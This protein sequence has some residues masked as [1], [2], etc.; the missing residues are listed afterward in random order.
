MRIKYFSLAMLATVIA[1][2]CSNEEVVET[3]ADP[4]GEAIDFLPS[5]GTTRATTTTITNLGAFNVYAKGIHVASGSLFSPFLVGD[6]ATGKPEVAIRGNVSGTSG[7]W[8]LKNNVYWPSDIE[9]ALFWA[10]S[11]MHVDE[12]VPASGL[13]VKG[14]VKFDNYSGPSIENYTPTKE[15]LSKV[16]TNDQGWYDGDNQKDLVS[17]FCQQTKNPHVNLNFHH[18]LS[19]IEITAS[20]KRLS[21]DKHNS[22]KVDIKGAWIVNVSPYGTLSAG[23]SYNQETQE[24]TDKPSWTPVT[25]ANKL[26]SYGTIYVE[27]REVPVSIKGSSTPTA[28]L[29]ILGINGRGNLMLIP[30]KMPQWD[31]VSTTTTGTYLLL[32]CRVE[33]QHTGT[34]AV[35]PGE[36]IYQPDDET[37]YHYH[38]LFP[39]MD[40]YDGAAYGLSAIPIPVDWAIGKKYT[41]SLDMCGDNTGAGKYPPN[42][43]ADNG[44]LADYLTKFIPESIRE[45][46]H[47]ITDIPAGKNVGDYVL[48]DPI[49][50]NVSVSNWEAGDTWVNGSDNTDQ[51]T[52][53]E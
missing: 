21:D 2:S 12:E 5:V 1:T 40:S 43:P 9:K 42:I 45:S 18:L 44:Q 14:V 34:V 3:N 20:S 52:V 8:T 23:F 15:D 31:G 35:E 41:Y 32:L 50:F 28:P 19:Q 11:D 16:V 22:R 24:A 48:D 51:S 13:C 36:P 29:N 26:E 7:K 10:F 6:N 46:V 27:D 4:T 39:V 47:I 30:Q 49:Q 53:G 25:D 33:L 17:A 38:Q 37:G